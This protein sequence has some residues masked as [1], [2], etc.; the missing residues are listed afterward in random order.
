M[1][2]RFP[3]R[4]RHAQTSAPKHPILG[5]L[6]LVITKSESARHRSKAINGVRSGAYEHGWPY[7]TQ[8]VPRRS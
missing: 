7:T 5:T 6:L 8:G 4:S 2:A 1:W 3:P